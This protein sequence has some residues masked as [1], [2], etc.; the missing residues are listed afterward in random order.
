MAYRLIIS[1]HADL[2]L[3]NIVRYLLYRLKNEQAAIH[4]LDGI[5][6]VYDHLE[7]NPEQFPLSQD[8]YLAGRG[9]HEAIVPQAP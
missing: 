9:Y 5:E 6:K 1:E 4:L 8:T 2:L 3:D 7:E